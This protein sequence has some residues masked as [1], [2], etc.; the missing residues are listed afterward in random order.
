MQRITGE[1]IA[2]D[3]GRGLAKKVREDTFP[4]GPDGMSIVRDDC[5]DPVV[6]AVKNECNQVRD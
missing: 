3:S 6:C 2:I 1:V 4:L 5:Y